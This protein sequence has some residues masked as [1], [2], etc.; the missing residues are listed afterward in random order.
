MDKT[1]IIPIILLILLIIV[2]VYGLQLNRQNSDL[3]REKQDLESK[4][5][6]L[7][8][9]ISELQ[10]KADTLNKELTI[11]KNERDKIQ[12]E[13]EGLQQEKDNLQRKYESLVR[14]RDVL[15]EKLKE[16]EKEPTVKA[17]E[18][19]TR[20]AV[21]LSE[22]YWSD[23]VQKKAELE[24]KLEKLTK[25]LLD[26]K[27]GIAEL[28]KNNKELQIKID[29]LAKEKERLTEDI[30]FKERTASIMSRD[31]VKER[32]GRKLAIEELNK[33]RLDNV[34]LKRELVL[35]NKGQ[36][37]LTS[38]LKEALEKKDTLEKRIIEI[39]SILREKSLA[40][41]SLKEQLTQAVRGARTP[42]VQEPASV[43]L[44][45]IVVKPETKLRGLRGEVVAVNA[46]DKFIIVDLGETAGVKPGMPM[47]V[48]RGN[49]E[50]AN[51]EIIETRKDI[52]AADIKE[53]F[54]T[55]TIQQGDTV[56]VR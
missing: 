48:L 2:A 36:M 46:E 41:D 40:L 5:S 14:E 29:E 4:I 26:T 45:P 31:L 32:E 33:L 43:E 6:S 27:S 25:E 56:V 12:G 30:Q 55:F 39:D 19:G 13:R 53:V 50:I 24:T 51:V 21:P 38:R 9:E 49:R 3:K 23:F 17:G 47:K 7:E 54:G 10:D 35:T 52:S 8:S 16:K 20:A 1:K 15:I 44:P 34:G 28:E 11:T 42:S 18:P 37:Q 22:E